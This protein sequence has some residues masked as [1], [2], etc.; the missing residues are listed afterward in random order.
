MDRVELRF[1]ANADQVN[2]IGD[3][4]N[5]QRANDVGRAAL[6]F[7]DWA[8]GELNRGHQICSFD[9]EGNCFVPVLLYTPEN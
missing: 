4:I 1:Q 5:Q 2:R 7:T 3:F 9:D 8:V 6:Q